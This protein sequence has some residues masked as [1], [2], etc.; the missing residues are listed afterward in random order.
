MRADDLVCRYGGEEFCVLLSRAGVPD[1][2]RFDERLRAWLAAQAASPGG[3]TIGY[4]AGA[5]SRLSTDKSVDD[6][7]QRADAALYQ[8]K[9]EGRGRL[10]KSRAPTEQAELKFE[11]PV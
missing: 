11:V 1:A 3:E 2:V 10:V 5:T 4:S 8:A 7:M 6:L 9:A